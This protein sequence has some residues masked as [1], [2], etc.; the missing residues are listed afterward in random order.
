MN[1]TNQEPDQELVTAAGAT[2]EWPDALGAWRLAALFG[3][4]VAAYGTGSGLAIL[5]AETSGM[6]GVFFIPAGITVAFLLRL[7]RRLWWVVLIGAGIAEVVM[8]LT[9]GYSATE[10]LGFA[11]ANVV[12]PLVGASIVTAT[13]GVVD[14]ARRRH[15]IWFTLG[16]V[17]IGP[18]VGAALGATA[19]RVLSGDE[20]LTT[21]GQWWLGDALGVVLVAGVILAWGSSRDRRSL[22]SV[23]GI[24]LVAGAMA[25]TVAIFALTDLPLMY[26]VLIGVIVAGV[27]F[28][29]RAV[30]MTALMV[31]LTIAVMLAANRGPLII[32]MTQASTL[33]FIKL[34]VGLFTLAGLLLAAES[35]GRELAVRKAA[36]STLEAE[37][38][39]RER[40]REQELMKRVQRGLLPDELLSWPG[41]D[42]AARYEA[43]DDTMEAGGDWYDTIQL[44]ESRIALMVGD[45]VGHGIESMISMGRL[46]TALTALAQNNDNPGTL[47]MELDKFA[48]GPDGTR[49]ATVFYA[50]IDFEAQQ[51]LYASAGHPPGLL[52]DSKGRPKW[53]DQ[54][55]GGPLT[56]ASDSPHRTSTS[57]PFSPGS[58]LILYSDGLIE[59]RGESLS[60]GMGRLEQLAAR[61]INRSATTICNELFQRLV[62]AEDLV[63]DA[64]VMVMGTEDAKNVYHQ[65]FPA[66]PEELRNMRSSIRSWVSGRR[67][68]EHMAEDLLIAVGEATSNAVWHAYEQSPDGDV[69]IRIE[70]VDGDLSVRVSDHGRWR[71]SRA[72]T[73]SPGLGTIILKRLTDELEIDT[74]SEGTD[75]TFLIRSRDESSLVDLRPHP[76]E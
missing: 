52:L 54:G 33:V 29:I 3:L 55:Q 28:G 37:G 57:T 14:L 9:G 76:A 25:L 6:Q 44:D 19:D 20:F 23:I 50:I 12:E 39:Q 49:Y 27:L 58:T 63:D 46:R 8:D 2:W 74:A 59:R 15:M 18:S 38:L 32:G 30:T 69:T 11:A 73:D 17:L 48:G 68:P 31:T 45:I 7:P 67:I 71:T 13:C 75:V 36:R 43:A 53:L 24:G 10:S 62:G 4:T 56:G 47:L 22:F 21:F 72:E 1:Q 16:A 34:Q 41:V 64:V 42:I 61:M 35:H 26:S 60:T 51:I 65:V 5:L 40:K 70:L 66:W